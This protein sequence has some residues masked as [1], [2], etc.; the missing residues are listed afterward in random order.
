[1]FLFNFTLYPGAVLKLI[2]SGIMLKTME[3]KSYSWREGGMRSGGVG[4]HER[5]NWIVLKVAADLNTHRAREVR[6]DL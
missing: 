5:G 2:N 4:K 1:M 3:I 6:D